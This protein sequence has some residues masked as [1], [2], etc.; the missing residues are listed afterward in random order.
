MNDPFKA[1]CGLECDATGICV[2]NKLCGGFAGFRCPDSRQVCV[3]AP[4]D[5]C[6]VQNGGADCGGVCVW[7]PELRTV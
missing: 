3:D 7:P 5:G 4:N 6:D 2:K 1:G